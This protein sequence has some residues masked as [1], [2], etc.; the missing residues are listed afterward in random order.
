M[1]CQNNH[2]EIVDRLLIAKAD[3]NLQLKVGMTLIYIY[4]TLLHM[5]F[6]NTTHR[7]F[8]STL[9]VYWCSETLVLFKSLCV[10]LS[11]SFDIMLKNP[12]S[13]TDIS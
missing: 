1:A 13:Y 9:G 3:V 12:I 7:A 5:G 4:T 10:M 8:A 11:I 2:G 6:W